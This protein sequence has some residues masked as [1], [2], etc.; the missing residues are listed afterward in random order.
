[1]YLRPVTCRTFCSTSKTNTNTHQ[2]LSLLLHSAQSDDDEDDDDD[3]SN[4]PQQQSFDFLINNDFL[5]KTLDFHVRTMGI[6]TEETLKI[7]F[8]P[9]QPPPSLSN[10]SELPDWVSSLSLNNSSNFIISGCYDGTIRAS[11]SKDLSILSEVKMHSSAIKAVATSA[12]TDLVAS[13]GKDQQTFVYSL[14]GK[15]GLLE[16]SIKLDS[17]NEHKYSVEALAFSNGPSSVLATG[18]FGGTVCL[19]DV[20]AP[21]S[22]EAAAPEK[23]RKKSAAAVAKEVRSLESS[24]RI[25]AHTRGVTG[26]LFGDASKS[27]EMITCSYDNSV[28]VWDTSTQDCVTTLN[29]SKVV[30]CM[31]RLYDGQIATGH[32]D[33][34]VR[35]WDVRQR[36]N[37]A[38]STGQLYKTLKPSHSAW[39][40]TIQGGGSTKPN[41]FVTGSYDGTVK[42]WDTRKIGELRT[43]DGGNGKKVLAVEMGE[44]NIYAGGESCKV[45]KFSI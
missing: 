1:M 25:S 34:G 16:T 28:K 4:K 14:D 3:S 10:S 38:I 27:S 9:T 15:K 44:K 29:G 35:L 2:T 21:A 31:A 39:V 32:P 20:L 18:D 13:A 17:A 11:S 5:R 26:I 41:L 33:C 45:N 12:T 24:I 23:K 6:S 22:E 40:S 43:S 37:D 36:A 7:H 42:L 8:L 30:C 19:W